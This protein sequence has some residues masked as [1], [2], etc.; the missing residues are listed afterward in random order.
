MPLLLLWVLTFPLPLPFSLEEEDDPAPDPDLRG[1]DG[2]E[3][4]EWMLHI[5]FRLAVLES[6]YQEIASSPRCR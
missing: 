1:E 2:A 6:W 4:V 3:E 5:L